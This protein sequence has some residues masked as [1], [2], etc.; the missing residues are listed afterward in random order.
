MRR[1]AE[2][3]RRLRCGFF[4]VAGVG[5]G[6]AITVAGIALSGGT[7]STPWLA[8]PASEYFKWEAL[9][10]APVTLLCWVLAAGVVYLLGRAV[11]GVGT[12]E[13]T[14]TQVGFAIAT[15]TLITLIPDAARAA[16]TSVGALSRADWE[17]A[18]ASPGS[19]DFVFL[20]TDMLA[21]LV[22]LLVLFTLAAARAERLR[23]WRAASVGVTGALLYQGVYLIFIR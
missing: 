10:I 1:L 20:W 21:Y 2:H 7:P 14:L 15:A 18:V 19:P 12:F 17:Q 22:G 23:G 8:I 13:A 3:P 4:A 6:Y 9:F 16:M 11:G 5:V